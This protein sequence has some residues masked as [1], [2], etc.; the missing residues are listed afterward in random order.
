MVFDA[1]G[2]TQADFKTR[3]RKLREVI[4]NC[5]SHYIELL[6]HR[7]CKARDYLADE[8]ERIIR[9]GGEG[10]MIRK[11]D[12]LYE[13]KR[14][15]KLLKVKKFDDAEAKVIGHEEGTGRL[16]GLLGAIRVREKSGLEFKIGSGFNDA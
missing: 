15:D 14:S 10:V 11:P 6:E 7:L 1:P 13:R 2:M 12:S 9:L 8:M 5:K 3:Y 16:V 4:G